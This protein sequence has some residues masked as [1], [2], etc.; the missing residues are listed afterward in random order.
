MKRAITLLSALVWASL[1][2]MA[3]VPHRM[4]VPDVEGYKT[5]KGDFHIHTV[6]TDAD[7]WPTN[8]VQEAY[9]EGLDF[10]S[11]TDHLDTRLQNQKHRLDS[12]FTANQD[13]SW[14]L[15]A[16]VAG[17]YDVIVIHGGEVSRG[18]PPGHFN[19]HFISSNVDICAGAEALDNKKGT[20]HFDVVRRALEISRQQGGINIWNH[21][22]WDSQAPNETVWYPEHTRLF[23]AG[24]LD[25]IEIFNGYNSLGGYSPE[26]H[27]WAVERNMIM[28]SGTDCHSMIDLTIDRA[29]GKFRP[30][31]LVFAS[32]RSEEGIREAVLARRTAI[33]GDGCVYG[34][35]ATLEPLLKACLE[36]SVVSKTDKKLVLKIVNHSSI[37]VQFAK[38]AGECKGLTYTRDCIIQPFDEVLLPFVQN[39]LEG[40]S[41]D[42]NI[43]FQVTN[44][45]IDA[46]VPLR[47]ELRY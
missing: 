2:L 7:V 47:W 38:P 28:L 8:R 31:T 12:V 40:S 10:I 43:N 37:P 29:H 11:I 20:K 23:E 4:V 17:K 42:F 6:F 36:V 9:L 34:T 41:K 13:L 46:G 35:Q 32:E 26:A 19:M 18:M 24:L 16:E 25:G 45:F 39:G 15:A 22:N 33:F 30:V 27:H 3:T 5:L 21:P 14:K 44:W 1:S